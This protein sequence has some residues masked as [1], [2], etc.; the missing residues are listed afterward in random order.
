MDNKQFNCVKCG[1]PHASERGKKMHELYCGDE[2]RKKKLAELIRQ[3]KARVRKTGKKKKVV[4]KSARR[5]ST[6][7]KIKHT[8][9]CRGNKT[10]TENL[11]PLR[12]IYRQCQECVGFG[13][14]ELIKT[15]PTTICPLHPFRLKGK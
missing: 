1:K 12:A 14:D 13:D 4:K 15:C 10:R 3:G 5:A 11:T 2:E 9:R 6:G 8:Y 7:P